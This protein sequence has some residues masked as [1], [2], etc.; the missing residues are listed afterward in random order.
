GD[1]L[2]GLPVSLGPQVKFDSAAGAGGGKEALVGF[3]FS[4]GSMLS[5]TAPT[6]PQLQTNVNVAQSDSWKGEYVTVK[7]QRAEVISNRTRKATLAE[8]FFWY[9]M[10]FGS[11]MGTVDGFV[12]SPPRLTATG[13]ILKEIVAQSGGAGAGAGA[14]RLGRWEFHVDFYR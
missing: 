7:P 6:A 13:G 8:R 11:F 4:V 1:P 10:V 5:A 2:A 9:S 3:E 14:G 12:L